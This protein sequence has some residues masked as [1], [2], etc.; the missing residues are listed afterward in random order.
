MGVWWW[1]AI[2]GIVVVIGAKFSGR[3]DRDAGG[4]PSN[5]WQGVDAAT[6][7]A[8]KATRSFLLDVAGE[9]MPNADGSSRQ[10][11][12]ALCRAGDA[13]EFR[14]EPANPYDQNAVAVYVLGRQV[15]YVPRQKAERILRDMED[16]RIISVS[17]YSITGGTKEKPS[18]GLVLDVIVK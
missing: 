6:E 2:A 4:K 15:G 14:H 7:G 11:V 18:L 16:S 8:D 1:M 9:A 5:D 17:V 13:V 3:R 12:L 10:R